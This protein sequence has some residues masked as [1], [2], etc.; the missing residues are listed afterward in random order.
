MSCLQRIPKLTL[1]DFQN[2]KNEGFSFELPQ[3]TIS[4][5]KKISELV[6][7]ASY[8]KTPVF[9]KRNKHRNNNYVD[10][11][12][13][14]TIFKVEK[15]EYQKSL[16]K[17]QV[18]INKLSDKNY[19]V[20]KDETLEIL[21]IIKE[22]MSEDDFEKLGKYIFTIASSNAFYSHVYAKLYSELMS[23]Y[24]IFEQIIE[25]T[26]IEY[27]KIFDEIS[28]SVSPDE[29]YE[30]FCIINSQ[31]D[32]R[33]SLSK[34]ISS[35]LNCDVIQSNFVIDILENLVNNFL[36]Y[37]EIEKMTTYCDETAENVKIIIENSFDVFKKL[38]EEDEVNIWLEINNKINSIS[39]MKT[40]N[41]KSFSKKT[42]FKFY[43]IVD[44]FKKNK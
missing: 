21:G 39:K 28:V 10:P 6:G 14:P 24:E 41:Y 20:I 15:D 11:N 30:K 18:Q 27:L 35:L 2:I 17:I 16:G 40:N 42:L 5:I 4:I 36:K 1:N 7:D 25:K 32:K 43:D 13:K 38:E 9:K 31:N 37:I 29:N 23:K 44:I 22:D 3:E 34:F 12:F 8:I 33:R 26:F 19:E